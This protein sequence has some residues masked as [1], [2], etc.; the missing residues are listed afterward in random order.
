MKEKKSKVEI[1]FKTHFMIPDITKEGV[2]SFLEQTIEGLKVKSVE[3]VPGKTTI[4]A[5]VNSNLRSLLTEQGSFDYSTEGIDRPNTFCITHN[6]PKKTQGTF[7]NIGKVQELEELVSELKKKISDAKNQES[8]T[9][10]TIETYQQQLNNTSIIIEQLDIEKGRLEEENNSLR[11]EVERLSARLENRAKAKISEVVVNSDLSKELKALE[12]LLEQK[13]KEYE[14]DKRMLQDQIGL[15]SLKLLAEKDKAEMA[16]ALELST[17]NSVKYSLRDELYAR[18]EEFAAREKAIKENEEVREKL[19]KENKDYS[20]KISRLESLIRK[21]EAKTITA[22][23]QLK[24]EEQAKEELNK[25]VNELE[26]K[27]RSLLVS[28]QKECITNEKQTDDINNKE[29]NEQ[30]NMLENELSKSV[31]DNIMLKRELDEAREELNKLSSVIEEKVNTKK[32]VLENAKVLECIKAEDVRIESMGIENI[33]TKDVESKKVDDQKVEVEVKSSEHKELKVEDTK[34]DEEN[35]KV[36]ELPTNKE[37]IE[38]LSKL[39][40][41]EEELAKTKKE[42]NEIQKILNNTKQ[43]LENEKILREEENIMQHTIRTQLEQKITKLTNIKTPTKYNAEISDEVENLREELEQAT[44]IIASL[45]IK[46][47]HLEEIAD[48][49]SS[50]TETMQSLQGQYELI[51]AVNTKLKESL[52]A[53]ESIKSNKKVD[54]VEELKKS[55]G[56]VVYAYKTMS[57]NAKELEKMFKEKKEQVEYLVSVLE[58]LGNLKK[59]NEVATVLKSLKDVIPFLKGFPEGFN[60]H[61]TMIDCLAKVTE[62]KQGKLQVYE[63]EIEKY[64]KMMQVADNKVTEYEDKLNFYFY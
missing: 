57:T 56:E 11:K 59:A 3:V 32:E 64:N 43:E 46:N 26:E 33:E 6:T 25:K 30:I 37:T 12:D 38:L 7:E 23:E 60:Q 8:E 29:L 63:D 14:D 20:K 52:F 61:K 1:L 4:K 24:K 19:R 35:N 50:C 53:A 22:T 44:K 40:L 36:Q 9:I 13:T 51:V 18:Q 47:K 42:Q 31:N 17:T 5:L 58:N 10:T 21:S 28:L 2:K 45:E 62:K 49:H 41:I 15:M 54:V 16:G 39:T 34:S 27:N 48:T 55:I